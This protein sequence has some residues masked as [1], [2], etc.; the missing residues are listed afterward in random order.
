MRNILEGHSRETFLRNILEKALLRTF[1][2]SITI[3][4]FFCFLYDVECI[5]YFAC[6]SYASYIIV[7]L[8]SPPPYSIFHSSTLPPSSSPFFYS[9][10]FL[11]FLPSSILPSSIFHSSSFFFSP[12]LQV[13][14]ALSHESCGR[15]V[16]GA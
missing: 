15:R 3:I 11:C 5:L 16:S 2:M 6:L 14:D 8:L 1:F 7:L 12:L 4:C 9:F 10:P 13:S